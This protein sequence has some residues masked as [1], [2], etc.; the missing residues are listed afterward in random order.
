MPKA[1]GTSKKSQSASQIPDK[2]AERVK[3][4]LAPT[5]EEGSDGEQ[6]A[7]PQNRLASPQSSFDDERQ[8]PGSVH[9]MPALP[10]ETGNLCFCKRH[11]QCTF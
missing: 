1:M 5:V 10:G 3:S 8:T 9:T 11:P 2:M 6:P 4:P 7:S